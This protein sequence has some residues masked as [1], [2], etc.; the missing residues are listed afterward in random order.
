MRPCLLV[1]AAVVG[2][3]VTLLSQQQA[4]PPAPGHVTLEL[5]PHGAPGAQ[6]N[7]ARR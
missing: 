2:F 6:P 5:W 1:V 4:W 7:S 3:S